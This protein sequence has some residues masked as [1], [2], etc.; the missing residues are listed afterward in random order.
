M[1]M[2]TSKKVRLNANAIQDSQFMTVNGVYQS[3][4]YCSDSGLQMIL[5]LLDNLRKE[6]AVMEYRLKSLERNSL[7]LVSSSNSADEKSWESE[8]SLLF[9]NLP[10]KTKLDADEFELKL[11][12]P[13]FRNIVV[14]T[15]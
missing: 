6:T 3:D 5:D 10:L 7:P 8:N 13:E 4:S 9:L 1:N 12:E 2:Q 15:V 14:S 11:N